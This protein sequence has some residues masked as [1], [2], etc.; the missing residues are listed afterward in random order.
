MYPLTAAEEFS[1]MASAEGSLQ[2][3]SYTATFPL[4]IN[5]GGDPLYILTLKDNSGLI[6]QYALVDA[7][8]YQEVYTAPSVKKLSA[9]Y[10]ATNQI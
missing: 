4:L 7:Q 5:V 3:K 2:E 9:D 1:A 6:K 8:D 10:A